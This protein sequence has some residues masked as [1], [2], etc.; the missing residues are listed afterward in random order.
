[1]NILFLPKL[2]PRADIIGGPILIYHRIKNLSSM[3]HR[4]MLIAPAY[5]EA[6]RKDK[7]L[8]PFCEKIIRIDSS[9]E[10]PRDEVEALYKRVNRPKV[11]LTGDGGYDEKIE[12]A[13]KLT[14]K[15]KHFDAVIAEYAMMGQYIEAN[16]S[17][18]PADTMTVISVHE[19]YTKAFKLRAAKGEDVSED[20]I[21]ELF[22]YEFKMYDVADRILTLTRED[23]DI[24]ISYAPGLKNKIRVVPHGV[25]TEF[26][27]PPK[28]KSWERNTKNI[29]YLGNFQHYPNVDAVK[30]FIIH[31]WDRIL[32]E[33]SDAKF[34][35]IGFNPP[36]ELLD[37]RSDNITV[38]EGGDDENVRRL[39][40]NSDVFVAPIELGTGFR[41]KLLEAMACGLPVVATR[42]ATFGINPIHG[43][44]MFITD[45]YNA[46]SEYVIMLLK[47]VELRKKIGNNALAL[48][49]RFDHKYAAEKLEQVLKERKGG[50]GR[51]N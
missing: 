16:R 40:W 38:R 32:R 4:I 26:Y 49:R 39:Y 41:G 8:E 22:N 2:F 51:S 36:R 28:K 48:S 37:L 13:L 5:T 17:L 12:N 1:M 20:T 31:C 23:G 46:F 50:N 9:R 25:D 47:D 29:L 18:I 42:L 24:L 15:E 19:C 30:N 10:R 3:G 27:T 21:K 11:F 7:S 33:V 6:D 35:A 45:D 34:Y 14:L 43:E 44:D